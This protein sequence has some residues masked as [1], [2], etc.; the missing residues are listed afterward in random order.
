MGWPTVTRAS[1]V[2]AL[3]VAVTIAFAFSVTFVLA[4]LLKRWMAWRVTENEEEV[5]PG[6]Q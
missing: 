3:A 1:W 6:Y 4:K 5:G 2:Q